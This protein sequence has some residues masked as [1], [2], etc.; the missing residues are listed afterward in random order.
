MEEEREGLSISDVIRIIFSQKWLALIIA[1]IIMLGVTVTLYFGYNPKVT[2]YVS[3]F[4]VSFPGS[5]SGK[6]PDNSPFK[7]TEIVSR[8]N[9]DAAKSSDI[10]RFGYIEVGTIYVNNDISITHIIGQQQESYYTIRVSAKHFKNRSDATDFVDALLQLPVNTLLNIADARDI[11]LSDFKNTTFYEDKID[12]LKTQVEY[13]ISVASDLVDST[14]NLSQNVR[15]LND[16]KRYDTELRATIGKMRQNLYVHDV[17]EVTSSYNN[18]LYV[19]EGDIVTKTREMELIFGRLKENDPTVDIVQ[20]SQR[21]EQLAEEISELEERKD[22][23]TS[24]LNGKNGQTMK[25]SEEFYQ[26]LVALGDE[27]EDL[28]GRYADSLRE[29]YIKYSFVAYTGALDMEGD[30]NIIVCILIGLIA[31]IFVAAVVAFIVGIK[32]SPKNVPAADNPPADNHP[33]DKPEQ[34]G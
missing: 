25:E 28:T 10:E 7:F 18:L 29:Y 22:I 5:E 32:K 24:Y 33:A 17:D 21:I 11:D 20:A 14:G 23:Y 15:L 30:L 6:F 4:T 12:I 1:I 34:N 2:D 8:D 13:L 3:T 31:G 9:M 19:V 26:E 27:L 16:I